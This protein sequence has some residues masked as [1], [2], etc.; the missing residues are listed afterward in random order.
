MAAVPH[1]VDDGLQDGSRVVG[2]GGAATAIDAGT[3]TD[4]RILNND[5]M[6]GVQSDNGRSKEQRAD[7]R[8]TRVQPV[9]VVDY[10]EEEPIYFGGIV[11]GRCFA[12]PRQARDH[13]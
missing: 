7:P 13:I 2:R 10:S 9:R 4:C 11:D 3:T 12:P 6:R 1:I 5:A 8:Q